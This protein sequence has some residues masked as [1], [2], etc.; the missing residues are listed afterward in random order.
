ML[1]VEKD[2]PRPVVMSGGEIHLGRRL[3][4]VKRL[5]QHVDIVALFPLAP[6]GCVSVVWFVPEAVITLRHAR[7]GTAE[8]YSL[9][10]ANR[11]RNYGHDMSSP[12][13]NL[14]STKQQQF[15]S[16]LLDV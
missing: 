5:P 8:I 1:E 16:R 14:L 11:A 6:L 7:N 15:S 4:A 10:Y 13:D 12:T 9:P 2:V 3:C